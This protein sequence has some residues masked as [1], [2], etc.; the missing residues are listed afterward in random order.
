M[1]TG[2]A[3]SLTLTSSC[4]SHIQLKDTAIRSAAVQINDTWIL[5]GSAAVRQRGCANSS[6]WILI[7]IA[8]L[9]IVV[10]GFLLR[11]AVKI[12]TRCAVFFAAVHTLL[13]VV[14]Y[15]IKFALQLSYNLGSLQFS[16]IRNSAILCLVHRFLPVRIFI[17]S[18]HVNYV[19][20]DASRVF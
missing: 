19:V 5:I 20:F 9:R 11:T 17:C 2:T 7:G 3:R 16:C 6:L 13:R 4:G 1:V 12:V 15:S 10:G 14:K 8:A 18:L